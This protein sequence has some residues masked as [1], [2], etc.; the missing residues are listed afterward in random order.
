MKIGIDISPIQGPHRYRGI[1]YSVINFVNN[2]P[3]NIKQNHSF[4]LYAENKDNLGDSLKLLNLKGVTYEV[5]HLSLGPRYT[6]ELPW[7]LKYIRSA[8]NQ[9]SSLLNLRFGSKDISNTKDI[10]VF[11][12]MAP[13]QP[14][15]RGRGCKKIVVLY[16]IIPYVLEKDYLW[17]FRTARANDFSILAALRCASRRYFYHLKARAIC[18]HADQLIAISERTKTDYT[19]FFSVDSKKITV[20]PLGINPLDVRRNVSKPQTRYK[21]TSWGYISNRNDL[22]ETTR[23]LLFVGGPDPRRRLGDLVAA[24]NI[25]QA[26]GHDIKLVLAGN[27]MTSPE[28]IPV[29]DSQFALRQTSYQDDLYFLGF[30]NDQEREWLYK[31]ALAFVFPSIYE[32]FG[33]PVLEAM[34]YGTPVIC[35][36]N[37][38]VEE[39]AGDAALYASNART[40]VSSVDKLLSDPKIVS[41]LAKLGKSQASKYTWASTSEN[42]FKV[43]LSK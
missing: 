19:E 38:A 20:V 11:I 42:I 7:K 35:Y 43:V 25:L 14:V 27:I 12:Q 26:Q 39:A 17:S 24:F 33:L 37:G 16:D 6:F 2:M 40:I 15:P 10:Q 3:D 21:R 22:T 28:A 18:R 1:G 13:E 34:Q 4:V 5:R 9:L 31:H 36:K 29:K 41:K 32:G 8:L 30:V 23:Y